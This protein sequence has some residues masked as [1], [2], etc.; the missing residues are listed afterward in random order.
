LAYGSDDAAD[1]SGVC[2]WWIWMEA[3]DMLPNAI[4]VI[5][6]LITIRH[7]SQC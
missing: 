5:I 3:N 7:S 6:S 2:I 4:D 1:N